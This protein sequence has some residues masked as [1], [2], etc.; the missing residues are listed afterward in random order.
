[1]AHHS[2][3]IIISPAGHTTETEESFEPPIV[4]DDILESD[5]SSTGQ[6]IHDN[7]VRPIRTLESVSRTR[8][9]IRMPAEIKSPAANYYSEI[10]WGNGFEQWPLVRFSTQGDGSCLFHAIANSFFRPYHT[11]ML[12]GK[13][14]PRSRMITTLRREL[15]ERLAMKVSDD[16][17]SPT[18]Y[19]QMNRGY[20]AQWAKDAKV[21]EYTLP[22]MQN[23]LN[24]NSY[25]G[26]GYIEFI[27]NALNKDIYVL[28]AMRRD[29]YRLVDEDLELIVKGNRNSIILYYMDGG[30]YELVGVRNAD[31]TFDTHFS[32][33]HTL[34]RFLY[35]RVQ[36]IIQSVRQNS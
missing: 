32:P 26:Y 1:M 9:F 31:G 27:G 5:Q 17:D 24:S 13:H 28:E 21:E 30:H 23:E 10:K 18:Y 4:A 14:V 22:Y 15:S 12:D 36:N 33:D 2:D 19:E 6:P 16:P 20:T 34:I 3:E 11:E 25:I 29:I 8:P 35:G 7:I